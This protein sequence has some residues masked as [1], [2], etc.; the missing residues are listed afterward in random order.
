MNQWVSFDEIR[1]KV[2]IE[3]ILNHYALEM[4]KTRGELKGRCPFPDHE[5]QRASFSANCEKNIFQ[6]F[7]CKKSGN[8]IDLVAFMEGV[9]IREAALL[10]Q[11]WFQ[12]RSDADSTASHSNRQSQK[13]AETTVVENKPLTFQLQLDPDHAYLKDRGLKIE[14]ASEFGLGY[15]SRGLM[16]DRI[17]IPIHNES[18]DRVAYAGRWPGEPPDDVE[19]YVLPPGFH[20]SQ[21]LFNL[22]RAR[23]LAG[24]KREL[25]VVEGFFTVFNFW[26]AGVYNVVALMGS[27]LGDKQ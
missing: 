5:D 17:A 3:D 1:S 7:G 24:K 14:T 26:Q 19:K 18:A 13:A 20:K 23:Q 8:L 15:C 27:S 22:H 6:C 2:S 10:I 12:V 9:A 21:V 25:I 11:E 16:K 4:R